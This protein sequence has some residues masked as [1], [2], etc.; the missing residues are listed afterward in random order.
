MKKKYF[1]ALSALG[2]ALFGGGCSEK[3]TE[4]E[5][6]PVETPFLINAADLTGVWYTQSYKMKG[7]TSY[8]VPSQPKFGVSDLW[9]LREIGLPIG[10]IIGFDGKGK[11]I[12]E[13]YKGDEYRSYGDMTKYTVDKNKLT[14]EVSVYD[15]ETDQ[16]VT[17]KQTWTIKDQN[18]AFFE[19]EMEDGTSF[20]FAR[21]AFFDSY[22]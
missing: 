18:N 12:Y 4:P 22:S 17:E 9:D 13:S 21:V 10:M 19:A 2:I 16:Q 20:R 5:L 14:I 7:A 11:G 1:Y 8:T 6:K 15:S 3:S